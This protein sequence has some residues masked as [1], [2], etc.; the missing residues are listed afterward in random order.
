MPCVHKAVQV[1]IVNIKLIIAPFKNDVLCDHHTGSHTDS[2]STNIDD[3]NEFIPQQVSVSA[4]DIISN[5]TA[6]D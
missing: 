2:K 1:F 5:H 4:Y 6:C 3:G